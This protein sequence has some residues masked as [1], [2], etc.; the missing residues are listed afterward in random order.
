MKVFQGYQHGIDLG[1]W[2]SQCDHTQE[3][4]DRFITEPDFDRIRDWGLD[5]VRVPV[6]YELLEDAEGNYREEGFGILQKVIG[7]CGCRDLNMVLD[8]H[9]TYGF[10]FDDGEEESGFFEVPAYQ[11]RFYRLWEELARRFGG[12]ADRLSFELL[13]EVT[14]KAYSDKWNEI[15][16]ECVRRIRRIAPEIPILIG[17][18]YNNSIEALKDLAPPQDE[19]IV[20]NFHFY[21]PLI[22]THQGAYWVPGMDTSFR[23]PLHSTY[24]EYEERSREQLDHY[25]RDMTGFDRERPFGPEFFE[26][27]LAEAVRVAEER[28]VPL[29]C[30]EYGVIS[31]AD[32]ED[33]EAWYRM[34]GSVF[35]RYGIGRAAWNYREMDF[36]LVDGSGRVVAERIV[37]LL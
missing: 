3:R 4:Y 17:G 16:G 7:W 18:Y 32:P 34:V 35:D 27:M 21:E 22:F 24:G 28:D 11:E 26:E 19:N 9:K 12:H 23:M 8:L 10:S 2:L 15:A 31:L 36:G 13:N 1:G 29:Y 14:D 30:G 6:D 37:P 20:Y 25:F 33:T 5:H